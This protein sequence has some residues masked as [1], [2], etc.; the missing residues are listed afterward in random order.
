MNR[1]AHGG[2]ARAGQRGSHRVHGIRRRSCGAS[3]EV[4]QVMHAEETNFIL[5]VAAI[6]K[7]AKQ[8]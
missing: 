2:L 3:G 6:A 7:L 5:R 1:D 8:R 4:G